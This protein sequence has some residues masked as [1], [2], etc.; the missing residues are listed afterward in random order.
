MLAPVTI[1]VCC[2]NRVLRNAIMGPERQPLAAKKSR[3]SASALTAQPRGWKGPFHARV[4]GERLADGRW[5]LGAGTHAAQCSFGKGV[6]ANGDALR[7]PARMPSGTDRWP[8]DV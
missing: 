1:S 7:F 2:G 5:N 8:V 6:V 3:A 4:L